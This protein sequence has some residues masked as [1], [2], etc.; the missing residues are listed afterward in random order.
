MTA[1]IV[2]INK[3]AVALA[4]DSA[5]TSTL[6]GGKKIFTS[7][8]KIFALSDTSPVGIMFYNNATFMSVPWDTIIKTFRRQLPKQGY[9]KL[10]DYISAFI[11]FLEKNNTIITEKMQG[12]F[13][14]NIA[15]G[16]FMGLIEDIESVVEKTINEHGPIDNKTIENIVLKIINDHADRWK[17][18]KGVAKGSLSKNTSKK[19]VAKNKEI[20]GD[21]I[22]I[23]FKNIPISK[24]RN[25]LFEIMEGLLHV[26][27]NEKINS[28]VVIAGFGER[29]AL[30]TLINMV[31]EG[32]F[33]NKL[34]H[35]P[36]SKKTIG[37]DMEAAIAAFAQ[38]EMVAR[39]M[40]GIDPLYKE[41]M[42]GYLS[43]LPE[44]FS[45]HLVRKLK[46]YKKSAKQKLKNNILRKCNK[47]I[48][49]FHEN[50]V[51]EGE[52]KF[53]GPIIDIVSVLPKSDLAALAES[54]ISLT[55]V[56][57]KY[58]PESETVAEPIDV[59]LISKGDGFIWIKRKHYFNPDLNPGFFARRYKE[60]GNE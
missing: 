59:A 37:V 54:L 10:E 22:E 7:A 4:A 19:I 38:R 55:I 40:N 27:T 17:G 25:K 46:G 56:K 42:K 14:G 24:A 33:D 2:I 50:M 44:Q 58:S 21:A 39:F 28:G 32:L 18:I 9:D 1:E 30:P 11:E 23:V 47:I 49:D 3:E 35:G 48:D 16:Y 12:E 15:I 60:E 41:I 34:K 5:V 45:E 6:A 31:V 53:S 8:D 36:I 20:I 29:E 57:R 51:R 43:Q 13:L 26:G 52:E